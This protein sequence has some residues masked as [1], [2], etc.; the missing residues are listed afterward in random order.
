MFNLRG[1]SRLSALSGG[2]WVY[3]ARVALETPL[4]VSAP[5]SP[6]ANAHVTAVGTRGACGF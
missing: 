6:V 2:R 4:K 5:H 1:T 3:A